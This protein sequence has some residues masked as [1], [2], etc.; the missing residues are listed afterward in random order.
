MYYQD[1]K[2]T[3]TQVKTQHQTRVMYGGC[4]DN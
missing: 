4:T 3:Q 2:N 1:K